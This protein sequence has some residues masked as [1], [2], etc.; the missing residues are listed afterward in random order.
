MD[1]FKTSKTA[2]KVA[3]S[4]EVFH[5]GTLSLMI[6]FPS[7]NIYTSFTVT[8]GR[9]F[10]E[11]LGDVIEAV[12]K[13]RDQEAKR[14]SGTFDPQ[15]ALAAWPVGLVQA[16]FS[17]VCPNTFAVTE[18]T[19]RQKMTKV[20]AVLEVLANARSRNHNKFQQFVSDVHSC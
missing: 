15:R 12:I 3:T 20:L 14:S 1:Q 10:G 13:H 17:A 5:N 6:I 2:I 7:C 19:V 4:S 9:K 16:F 11:A 8:A 18:K